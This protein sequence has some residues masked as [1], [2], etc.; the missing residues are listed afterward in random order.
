MLKDSG[1][2]EYHQESS[3]FMVQEEGKGVMPIKSQKLRNMLML[4]AQN[5]CVPLLASCSN[6]SFVA[7]CQAVAVLLKARCAATQLRR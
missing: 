6:K 3:M 4:S 1:N 7:D 2:K 5:L